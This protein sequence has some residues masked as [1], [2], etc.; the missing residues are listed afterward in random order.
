MNI[1]FQFVW[2]T[3]SGDLF[4]PNLRLGEVLGAAPI[5]SF[6]NFDQIELKK[7]NEQFFTFLGPRRLLKNETEFRESLNNEIQHFVRMNRPQNDDREQG[8]K[9]NLKLRPNNSSS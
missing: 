8:R 4:F 1:A 5:E 3:L 6:S 2:E 9:M 7:K